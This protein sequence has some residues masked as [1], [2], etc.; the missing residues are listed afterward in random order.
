MR[1]PVILQ[2]ICEFANVILDM[3]CYATTQ[4]MGWMHRL[5]KEQPPKLT[6]TLTYT[7]EISDQC[8]KVTS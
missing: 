2:D 6:I 8:F 1:N 7:S 4:R 3:A 5:L